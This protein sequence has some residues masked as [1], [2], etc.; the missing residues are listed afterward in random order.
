MTV[1]LPSPT[2]TARRR[3]AALLAGFGTLFWVYT[4]FAIARLPAGDGTGFQWLAVIP[5]GAIF[6]LFVLPAWLLVALG[7]WPRVAILGALVGLVL[8]AVTWAQLLG[9]FPKG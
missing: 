2:T 8:L 7:R 5:L 6:V 4:F 1:S 9:E 3:L